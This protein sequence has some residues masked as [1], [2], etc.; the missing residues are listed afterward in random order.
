MVSPL[1]SLI[2]QPG[3]TTGNAAQDLAGLVGAWSGLQNS[4]QNSRALDMQE[5]QMQ[6]EQQS[7]AEQAEIR[8][9]ARDAVIAHSI[10]DPERRIQFLARRA[11]ELEN[12]GRD[13]SDTRQIMAMPFEE[14]NAELVRDAAILTSMYPGGEKALL[15]ELGIGGGGPD[16]GN[17]GQYNPRDYTVDSWAQFMESRDPSVLQ[18]YESQRNIDIGG[19]PHRFDPARGGYFP[20]EVGEG[21]AQPQGG[22]QQPA[23]GAGSR[24][25]QGRTI[26]AEDVGTSQATIDT[27]RQRATNKVDKEAA[28]PK[29]YQSM[30]SGMQRSERLL[31]TVNSLEDRVGVMTTG[32]VGAATDWVPGSPSRDFAADVDTVKANIGFDELDRMRRESPTG[33]ALGQVSEREIAFLQSVIANLENSQSPEQFRRNLQKVKEATTT[34]WGNVRS[35]YERDYGPAELPG[36]DSQSQGSNNIDD[37]VNQYA[38]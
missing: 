24:Q 33:G 10:K 36:D 13:A 12:Q 19:V 31:E 35:A 29:I 23:P 27:A 6:S 38:D 25:P 5:Q 37:L 11:D 20:A 2:A 21:G 8:D 32:P 18:R 15:S 28:Q 7:A 26:T 22:R 17:I 34:S 14:Q 16:A 9:G 1:Q 30:V 3:G 4:R